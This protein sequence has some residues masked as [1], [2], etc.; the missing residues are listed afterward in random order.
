M[1]G[2]APGPPSSAFLEAVL[3]L[4]GAEIVTWPLAADQPPPHFAILNSTDTEQGT[5]IA[6]LD[7]EI[8]LKKKKKIGTLTLEHV[9][10]D[11]LNSLEIPCFLPQTIADL[12][13]HEV[14]P[15]L[16]EHLFAPVETRI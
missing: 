1:L 10:V 11:Q 13:S 14:L 4:A 3:S 8:S 12:F 9:A 7:S 2:D 16:A 15:P 5:L 6:T